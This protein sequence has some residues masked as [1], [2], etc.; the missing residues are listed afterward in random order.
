[1]NI[2]EPYMVF[3]LEER[4]AKNVLEILMPKLL[5]G[6]KFQY[7]WFQGKDAL[8]QKVAKTMKNWQQPNSCF[9]ILHD[10]D[11]N[12]CV[13]LKNELVELCEECRRPYLVRIVCRE[14]E[15]WYWGDLYAVSQTY[16]EFE[17]DNYKNRAKYRN[18]DEIHKPADELKRW[19]PEFKKTK[20]SRTIPPKMDISRNISPS[21]QC[22]VDGVQRLADNMPMPNSS[23]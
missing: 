19:I 10:Q 8:Q 17:A 16:T 7:F 13:C 22:F 23:I 2:H 4:S 9:V 21:F 15:S 20:A 11:A 14:L 18:P 1:M 5:S 6:V 12:D 3:L